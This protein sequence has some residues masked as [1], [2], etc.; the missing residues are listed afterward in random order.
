MLGR[1]KKVGQ[2]L[3]RVPRVRIHHVTLQ[4]G[5]VAPRLA[6]CLPYTIQHRRDRNK[7]KVTGRKRAEIRP[8]GL[9]TVSNTR[10]RASNEPI[11]NELN[12]N[13]RLKASASI[14]SVHPK[15]SGRVLPRIIHQRSLLIPAPGH[16]REI[17]TSHRASA[18]N[19]TTSKTPL[20]GQLA[21]AIWRQ[22]ARAQLAITTSRRISKPPTGRPRSPPLDRSHRSL[23][24]MP[25][26]RMPIPSRRRI[27]P[28]TRR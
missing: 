22:R 16:S 19:M 28:N 17:S 23:R 18:M 27:S 7:R 21:V 26:V 24:H 6:V 5:R 11:S 15:D 25:A 4:F 12:S 20:I 1:V 8:V 2:P 9:H 3:H 13:V 10:R 14:S